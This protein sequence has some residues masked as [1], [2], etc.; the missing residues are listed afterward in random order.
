MTIKKLI[1]RQVCLTE[2]LS[3]FNFDISH[4][5]GE[6]NTKANLV[7]CHPNNFPVNNYNDQQQV[8][9]PTIL[10]PERLEIS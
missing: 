7:T 4:T 1:N 8:L 10:P 3:R 2:F 9:L 5:R 6:K